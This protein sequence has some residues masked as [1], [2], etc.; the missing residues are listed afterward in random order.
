MTYIAGDLSTDHYST[1]TPQSRVEEA[2]PEVLPPPAWR[3]RL[4]EALDTASVMAL[5]LT[6]VGLW[7]AGAWIVWSVIRY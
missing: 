7:L 2:E 5:T 1:H 4:T 3:T 6:L